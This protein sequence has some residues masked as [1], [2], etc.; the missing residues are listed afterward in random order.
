MKTFPCYRQCLRFFCR[1]KKLI[2]NYKY[3]SHLSF[4]SHQRKH[5]PSLT[6]FFSR[7]KY[8]SVISS[9]HMIH[10]SFKIKDFVR[11]A[12]SFQKTTQN[13]KY[14]LSQLQA[15]EAI[16]EKF[17]QHVCQCLY[18]KAKFLT[19]YAMNSNS[20]EHFQPTC[21]LQQL[22]LSSWVTLFPNKFIK[23]LKNLRP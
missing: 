6:T 1:G 22:H 19:I 12:H 4:Y 15:R 13:F 5:N 7:I 18:Q 16:P 20:I 17:I 3:F 14:I 11:S 10:Y 8:P 21:K 9:P 23:I 2:R